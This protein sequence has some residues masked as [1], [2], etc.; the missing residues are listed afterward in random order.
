M[1]FISILIA[2]F[3]EQHRGA[4]AQPR[5]F[6]L[7]QRYI[8]SLDALLN[9]G[10]RHHGILA[11]WV[12]V[13]PVLMVAEAI[14][15]GLGRMG[16]GLGWVADVVVLSLVIDFKSVLQRLSALQSDLRQHH[17]EV[18][19]QRLGFPALS[20]PSLS[21]LVARGIELAVLDIHA[22][23]LA[24]LFWYCL[25]PGPTGALL[26]VMAMLL[27]REWGN[28]RN[29]DFGRF[30][31]KAFYYLDWLPLHLTAMA[32][33]IVGNF[34]D[35]LF[36]WRSQATDSGSSP[37]I[38]LASAAGA[39]GIRLGDSTQASRLYGGL[40]LGVGEAPDTDHLRSAE[41]M[42]WRT[43]VVWLVVIGLMTIAAM[44]GG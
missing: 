17:L 3:V 34:E 19:A 2:L 9:S 33:A 6:A 24:I 40:E 42:F 27:S 31:Q 29:N 4:A 36:C 15:F 13:L 28:D 8:R 39:L 41:G 23:L 20:P 18:V 5:V 44:V 7:F 22:H 1:N 37:R 11:W 21:E 10:E 26:Y 16:L 32:F 35:A 14:S 12:A 30:A 43:L 25:L 38:I